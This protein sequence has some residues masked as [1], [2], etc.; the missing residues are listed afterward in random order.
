L[1]S[2]FLNAQC[3]GKP[4]AN[5]QIYL[6]DAHHN[7]TPIGIPGEL[8]LAGKG[9]ARGY[10]NRPELTLSKFIEVNLFGEPKRLYKTGDLARW[11]KD[12]NLEYLGRLD[13]QV[14][15]RGF[16]IELGEI[17]TTLTQHETVREA[18]VVLIK[19]DGNPRLA[20]YVTLTTPTDD[21]ASV[22]RTWL[23]ARLPDYLIPAH[24]MVLEQLPLTPNGKIDRNALPAPDLAPPPEVLKEPQSEVEHLLSQIWSEVL[25]YDITNTN[26]D[27]FEAG[28]H[29]LLATQLVSRIRERFAVEMPLKTVFEHAR[30]QE[31]AD[32]LAHARNIP[33][34]D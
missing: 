28:G 11:R 23:K 31:Q 15:L 19:D 30:L 29:S 20:A 27:F 6:L 13:H 4:I 21:T 17:E 5:T 18:V 34:S 9:L 33:L 3:I 32:W 1:N 8:C 25:G 14:K 16:R 10:L 24:I 26:T 7:P 12:G 2:S 22:L